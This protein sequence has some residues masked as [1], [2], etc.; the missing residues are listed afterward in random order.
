MA[1]KKKKKVKKSPKFYR[2]IPEKVILKKGIGELIKKQW[3]LLSVGFVSFVLLVILF[4]LSF[5]ILQNM[6]ILKNQQAQKTSLINKVHYWQGILQKHP[7]YR[8]GYLELSILEYQLKNYKAAR[9]YVKKSLEL[10]PNY[11]RGKEMEK[12]LD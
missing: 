12:I 7:D 9:E 2:S 11:E 1:K 5:L 3:I 10:D 4:G 8:D 6:R